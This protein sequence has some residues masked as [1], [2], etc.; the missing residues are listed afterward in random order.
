M[1]RIFILIALI[2]PAHLFA[3]FT[4]V[5]DTTITAEVDKVLL[6]MPWT[7]GL[8]AAQYNTMDLDGD[9]KDDL[10]LFDR[11]GNKV[12]T[13][14]A[15]GNTYRYAPDYEKIFPADIENWLLLRDFNR[16]GKKDIF[17]EIGRAS[18]R[19]RV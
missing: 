8:N 17:T 14:L 11:M 19:E 16:D 5:L 13:F 6:P 4:Y 3:Q 2:I 1:V 18:C 9:Q 12:I 15:V 7:G 10:V